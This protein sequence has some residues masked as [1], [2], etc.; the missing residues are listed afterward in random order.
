M[1]IPSR[2]VVFPDE[3]HLVLGHG[4][5]YVHPKFLS[6]ETYADPFC[7]LRW[8]YEVFRWFDEY[9]GDNTLR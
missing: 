3:N 6:D 5:R 7:S 2:L 1:G 4:N 9:V 8:Y